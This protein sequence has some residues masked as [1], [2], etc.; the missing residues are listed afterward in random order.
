MEQQSQYERRAASG[1]VMLLAKRQGRRDRSVHFFW[2]KINGT[3]RIYCVHPRQN[4]PGFTEGT[5]F[6]TRNGGLLTDAK[7]EN[8]LDFP[9]PLDFD[10]HFQR[11]DTQFQRRIDIREIKSRSATDI[12]PGQ[13]LIV[14]AFLERS[15]HAD[16]YNICSR[17]SLQ[18][19]CND[20]DVHFNNTHRPMERLALLDIDDTILTIEHSQ[21]NDNL[22]R[23]EFNNR[24]FKLVIKE[25]SIVSTRQHTDGIIA[26]AQLGD[27]ITDTSAFANSWP[28]KAQ[29]FIAAVI[30]ISS[31]KSSALIFCMRRVLQAKLMKDPASNMGIFWIRVEQD[32]LVCIEQE[33]SQEDLANV[34][35]AAL[36]NDAPI[37]PTAASANDLASAMRFTAVMGIPFCCPICANDKGW[38]A[39]PRNAS[40]RTTPQPRTAQT[41]HTASFAWI[42]DANQDSALKHCP[43]GSSFCTNHAE[44]IPGEVSNTPSEI[45]FQVWGK[46]NLLV[47][48]GF[49][50]DFD[51]TILRIAMAMPQ[52]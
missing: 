8:I 31:D 9:S 51:W 7:N 1:L 12:G 43:F 37:I 11:A 22:T 16:R 38:I 5:T 42:F 49:L 26:T 18:V 47:R 36:I 27:T 28:A 39:P 21:A 19:I 29:R 52:V 44:H 34:D 3:E 24:T 40:I 6:E 48:L 30:F 13:Y 4:I 33:I 32:G 35:L 50:N 46:T 45:Y 15:G 25:D 14:N 10:L 23:R 20:V 17:T 41:K 2:T